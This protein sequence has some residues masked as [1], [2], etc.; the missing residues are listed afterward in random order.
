MNVED[1]RKIERPPIVVGREYTFFAEMQEEYE[2]E[3]KRMRNYTGKLVTVLEVEKADSDATLYKV[4]AR[5]GFVFSAQQEEINDWDRDLGQYFWPD[6]TWG[7]EH[8]TFAIIN[9]EQP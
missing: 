8:D 9:E 5:D 2:P 3:H 7:P 1:A 4:M 6:A